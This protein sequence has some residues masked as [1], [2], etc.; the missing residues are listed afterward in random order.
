[1]ETRIYAW[2]M[3]KIPFIRFST[4]YSSL[5]GK[6]YREG[7]DML[8]PGDIL[9]TK[10]KWKLTSFLIPGE[11]PHAALCVRKSPQEGFEV[12]E[13]TRVG[14]RMSEFFDLCHEADHVLILRCLAW[15]DEY[16]KKVVETGLSYEGTDYDI[17]FELGVKS[18]YCS[19]L[20]VAS[21]PEKRLQVSYDDFIG[22]GR[23]YISPTGLL[24][25]KNI[26]VVWDS[27]QSRRV[28]RY[29]KTKSAH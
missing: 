10:D 8:R 23:P 13:M 20:I 6:T 12:A 26:E 29:A 14:Y 27:S 22:L 21:D 2:V 25:A 16:V 24:R 4:Y 15:D 9:L 5:H 11:F 7:Y 28:E 3:D 1:M 17:A 19:E 18:L